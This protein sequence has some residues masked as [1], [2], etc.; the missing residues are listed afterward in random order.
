M[1]SIAAL[2]GVCRALAQGSGAMVISVEY[3]LAPEHRFPRAPED[4]IAAARWVIAHAA[5]LGGD[6]S[7]IAVAGDSAGGNLAALAALACRR[8]IC[9]Q[10]LVYP[11]TDLT[12]A[13]PSHQHFAE[14]Y[15]L[16]KLMMDWLLGH[17]I[18][19]GQLTDPLASPFH[20]EDLRG[21]PPA[22][23]MTAGFDPLRDEGRAYAERLQKAGVAVEDR[24]YP[25]LIHGFISMCGALDT[26][27]GA[28]DDAI[29]ALR[30][31]FSA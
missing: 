20:V 23:V 30:R 3:R 14:G 1:G 16:T 4:A 27:S 11:V 28:L 18:D 6:A 21:A 25:S 17:Y 5:A 15:V 24:L 8:E 9:F 19:D 13:H 7:R 31:A 10:L 12:R 29:R 22:F 2:D 26:A